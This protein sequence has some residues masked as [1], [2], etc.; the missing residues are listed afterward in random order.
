MNLKFSWPILAILALAV[1]LISLGLGQSGLQ[2]RSFPPTLAPESSGL[3]I[4]QRPPRSDYFRAPFRGSFRHS[5]GFDHDVAQPFRDTNGYLLTW[6]DVQ[7]PAGTP[8]G[9][10]DGHAGYDWIMPTGTPLIAVGNGIVEFAGQEQPYVCP[11]LDNRTVA[12][13]RVIIAHTLPSGVQ[14]RSVYAHLSRISVR[15]GST[16]RAGQVIGLSGDTGCS[17]TPHLHF[18]VRRLNGTNNGRAVSVD[19]YG[20]AGNRPDPWAT[21]PEGASSSWLWAS[22]QAP[23]LFTH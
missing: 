12:G 20:W 3:L 11:I 13:L 8:G 5:S 2:A 10:L 15:P 6:Q 19:P 4:A 16:A 7:V 14:V 21:H 22:G 1:L 18:E 23:Q 17:R 9:N